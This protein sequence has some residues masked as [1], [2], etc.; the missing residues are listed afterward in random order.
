[1]SDTFLEISPGKRRRLVEYVRNDLLEKAGAERPFDLPLAS[2]SWTWLERMQSALADVSCSQRSF[3]DLAASW[4]DYL[5][6][7]PEIQSSELQRRLHQFIVT[8]DAILEATA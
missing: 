6:T 7:L 8:R 5:A 4:E 3:D 2:A 1:M